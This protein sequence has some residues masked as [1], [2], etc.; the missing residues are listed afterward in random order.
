[1]LVGD[2]LLSGKHFLVLAVVPAVVVMLGLFLTRTPYGIAIRAA[3]EN[4]DAARLAGINPNRVSTLVW[5]LSGG[6][7]AL[8]VVMF[9][10]VRGVLAGLPSRRSGPACCC[11]PSPPR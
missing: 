4:A 7:A 10:P 11:G 2:F 6:L 9:N 8:T 5:V 1:M 3:A